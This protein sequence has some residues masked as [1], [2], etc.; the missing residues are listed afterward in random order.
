MAQDQWELFI[1][2][3]GPLRVQYESDISA[4]S[5]SPCLSSMHLILPHTIEYTN[6]HYMVTIPSQVVILRLVKITF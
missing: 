6:Y 1:E 5:C 3:L 2:M 4:T